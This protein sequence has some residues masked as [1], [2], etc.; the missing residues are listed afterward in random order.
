MGNLGKLRRDVT[1]T[2]DGETLTVTVRKI[3]MADVLRYL[4][5]I[6]SIYSSLVPSDVG[7]AIAQVADDDDKAQKAAQG[8]AIAYAIAVAGVVGIRGGGLDGVRL[9]FE[10]SDDCLTPQELEDTSAPEPEGRLK[11]LFAIV[12]AISEMSGLEGL[13]RR[14]D[15]GEKAAPEG[16]EPQ[17]A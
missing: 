1:V 9:C 3:G 4:N 15:A 6:P 12:E 16:A 8:L 14:P 13:F 2:V 10:P 11:P 17:G 7:E 5:R